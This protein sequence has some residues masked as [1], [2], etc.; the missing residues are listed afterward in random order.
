M[1]GSVSLGYFISLLGSKRAM[2]SLALPCVV[3]WLLVYFG[4]SY[5]HILVAR[6]F[7]GYAGG[8][9]QTSLI[10]FNSEISND[11]VRGRLGSSMM[12]IRNFGILFG[13]TLG[14]TLGYSLIPCISI[15]LPIIFV[16]CFALL[17]NTPQFYL[18]KGEYRVSDQLINCLFG[19]LYQYLAAT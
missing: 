19:Y 5:Y 2:L 8:G 3:F 14:A 13:Y 4:S 11:D 6:L 17:P 12:V 7:S 16:I 1:L 9:I 18:E 10:L 15:I